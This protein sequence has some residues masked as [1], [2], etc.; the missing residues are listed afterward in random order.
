MKPFKLAGA[1]PALVFSLSLG[2][3]TGAHAGSINPTFQSF[4]DLNAA[5]STTVDFTGDGIPTDPSAIATF[6]GSNGDTLLLGLTAHQRFANP[7]LGNDGA[8]TYS[9]QAG[10]NDGTPGNPGNRATWNFAWFAEV[11]GENGSTL[12]D[13]GVTLLYDLDPGIGTDESDLGSWD[14]GAS[15]SADPNISDTLFQ[16]SQNATFG[17]LANDFPG[18]ISAP[19]FTAFDPFAAGQYSFA[20]RSTLGEV[21]INVEVSPVPLPAAGWLLLS[22]FGGLGLVARRRRKAA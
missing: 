6:A 15:A 17:F 18:F 1:I 10:A 3:V 11:I 16:S 9:A 8:G 19:S 4:G 21:A 12:N 20:L 7:P 2:A 13:Y 14:I 22:A 5:T